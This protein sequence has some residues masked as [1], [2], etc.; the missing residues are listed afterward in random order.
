MVGTVG[1]LRAGAAAAAA[2]RMAAD[3]VVPTTSA[4]NASRPRRDTRSEPNIMPPGSRSEPAQ[5]QRNVSTPLPAVN[6]RWTG[7]TEVHPIGPGP[8]AWMSGEGTPHA[9]HAQETEKDRD[10]RIARPR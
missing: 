6:P 7:A 10:G 9:G 1:A 2:G 3:A 5:S 4:V 8:R